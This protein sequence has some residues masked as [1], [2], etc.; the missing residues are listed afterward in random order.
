M[1]D[2]L[3]CDGWIED[4][5]FSPNGLYVVTAGGLPDGSGEARVWGSLSGAAFTPP[6]KHAH[7]LTRARFSPDGNLIAVAGTSPLGDTGEVRLWQ[8]RPRAEPVVAWGRD[9]WGPVLALSAD[10]SRMAARQAGPAGEREVRVWATSTGEPLTPPLPH[11]V[12]V[13]FAEFSPDGRRLLTTAPDSIADP[14]P[15]REGP[16]KEAAWVW[17]VATGELAGPPLRHPDAPVRLARFSADGRRVLTVRSGGGGER[18]FH[19]VRAWEVGQDRPIGPPLKLETGFRGILDARFSPDG[20]RVGLAAFPLLARAWDVATGNPVTPVLKIGG[21]LGGGGSYQDQCVSFSPDGRHVAI[22]FGS[23]AAQVWDIA[24]GRP[25]FPLLTH[26][27]RIN[28]VTFSP[29]G[30]LLL[31]ASD[32]GARLWRAADGTAATP[33]LEPSQKVTRAAFGPDGRQILTVTAD[34]LRVWDPITGHPVT[35]PIRKGTDHER[36]AF[37][38]DGRRLVVVRRDVILAVDLAP[39]TRPAEDLVQLT[40]VLTGHRV[41]ASGSLGAVRHERLLPPAW[42]DSREAA[43]GRAAQWVLWHPVKAMNDLGLLALEEPLLGSD[44]VGESWQ[45]LRA[46]YPDEFPRRP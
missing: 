5:A 37:S 40:Q 25:A 17:D 46:R 15:G 24:A 26:E 31:T 27:D 41:E 8:W 13:G 19:E 10:G 6:L 35:P 28:H 1:G 30:R 22:A 14:V 21:W 16:P 43:A 34:T 2:P 42:Y 39:D 45:A 32:R 29:D 23:N 38:A 18:A 20:T 3:R 9:R 36:E 44:P 12:P 11:P 33:P 7:W 4:A